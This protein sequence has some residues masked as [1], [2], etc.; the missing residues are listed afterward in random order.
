MVNICCCCF[1]QFLFVLAILLYN[2]QIIL[3]IVN[4][5]KKF[6]R[7]TLMS[8]MK[9]GLCAIILNGYTQ[10]SSFFCMCIVKDVII[11]FVQKKERTTI[12]YII[13]MI[14]KNSNKSYNNPQ[15]SNKGISLYIYIYACFGKHVVE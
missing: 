2:R 15:E 1:W 8:K 14:R 5:T 4:I 3:I 12:I 7:R 9:E 13:I 10:I 11:V 6:K